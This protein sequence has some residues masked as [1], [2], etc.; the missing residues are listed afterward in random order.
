MRWAISW[1]LA[2]RA[3]ERVLRELV[4]QSRPGR[5]VR[6]VDLLQVGL[7]R[8]VEVRPEPSPALPHHAARD[9]A[10]DPRTRRRARPAGSR[11]QRRAARPRG[12]SRSASRSACRFSGSLPQIPT[13]CCP[14]SHSVL[15]APSLVVPS[16]VVAADAA[17]AGAR[18]SVVAV[19]AAAIVAQRVV[20]MVVSF[21]SVTLAPTLHERCAADVSRVFGECKAIAGASA[22]RRA[23]RLD[24]RM[25]D[26]NG[27]VVVVEDEPSIADVERLYLTG[28]G[29]GVHLERDG[30]DGLA[31][32][33]R[34]R[35]VAVV[36]D[37]GLPGMDGIAVCRA[38]R[39][40]GDWTPVVFVTARDDEV[41]RVLGIEL[42]ADDLPHETVLAARA[43][44]AHPRHPA[45]GRAGHTA[46]LR[47]RAGTAGPG[48]PHRRGGRG[49]RALH[50]NRVRP[51][52]PPD[53]VAR[54]G[55]RPRAAALRRVGSRRPTEAAVPWMCTS[56]RCGRSSGTRGPIRTVRGVGYAADAR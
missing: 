39:D 19:M 55:V 51:A 30:I 41:D 32:I 35:P 9:P 5:P 25:S 1:T 49:R 11:G 56:P 13:R 10:R 37:V 47:T 34:L 36:L 22:V 2:V 46:R 26:R 7:Q 54:A 45:P 18:N 29:F 17:A 6:V 20:R 8:L 40:S 15:V 50:G 24:G 28:A 16:L 12:R 38:L 43:G 31:A 21:R 3:V 33:R 44:G 52:R 53:G 14:R 23:M 4:D 48:P 27:L 42:G